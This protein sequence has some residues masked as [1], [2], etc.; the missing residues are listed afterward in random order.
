MTIYSG[1][2]EGVTSVIATLAPDRRYRAK[3]NGKAID[4]VVIHDGAY[5]VRVPVDGPG[6]GKLEIAPL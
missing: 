5:D 1:R 3:W 4:M 6:T 2:D